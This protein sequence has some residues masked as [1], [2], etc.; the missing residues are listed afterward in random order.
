MN[1]SDTDYAA[2]ANMLPLRA[3]NQARQLFVRE[4]VLFGARCCSATQTAPD[5]IGGRQA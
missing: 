5:S 3:N 2:F 1:L 4:R